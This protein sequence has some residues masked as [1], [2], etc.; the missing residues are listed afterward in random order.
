MK[1]RMASAID[2]HTTLE[3][4]FHDLLRD[5][6]AVERVELSEAS[7]VYLL[8]LCTEFAGRDAL[9]AATARDER[10]TPALAELYQRAVMSAPR[11]RFNAYRQLG[12]IALMVAGFFAPH[13]ER[14]LVDV[15]YYVRMGGAAYHQA[16][17]LS[18]TGVR[19]LFSQL[20]ASYAQLVEVLTRVAERTTLPVAG[21]VAA[22]YERFL[23][24]PRSSDLQQRLVRQ[25]LIPGWAVEAA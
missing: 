14:S 8:G 15:D 10:G 20:A 19:G 9:Y 16:S 4:F 2:T 5:A 18:N 3:G 6:L 25:G 24:N 17:S 11:E 12:D 22:L 7:K 13:I 21:D 23:R 1:L